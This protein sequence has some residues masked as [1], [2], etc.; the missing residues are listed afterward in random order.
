MSD[1]T[2]IVVELTNSHRSL[3]VGSLDW[4]MI[5]A[6]CGA[7]IWEAADDRWGPDGTWGWTAEEASALAD[8]IAEHPYPL[9]AGSAAAPLDLGGAA[10]GTG[11]APLGDG[12]SPAERTGRLVAFL[13]EGGFR[14]KAVVVPPDG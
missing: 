14:W 7:S 1:Q 2:I 12:L 3:R 8:A 4:T 10:V 11:S 6:H 5:A 13:R 9:C